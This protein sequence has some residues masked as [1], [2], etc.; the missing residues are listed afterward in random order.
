MPGCRRSFALPTVNPPSAV[1]DVQ[2]YAQTSYTLAPTFTAS[3]QISATSAG[4]PSVTLN[5]IWRGI[6]LQYVP[7]FNYFSLTVRHSQTNSPVTVCY[8]TPPAGAPY[9]LTPW[10]SVWTSVLAPVAGLGWADGLGLLGPPDPALKTGASVPNW[11][12]TLQPLPSFGG[13]TFL[14]QAYA[15]DS[16]L[17]PAASAYMISNTQTVTLN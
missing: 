2:G 10:G 5:A 3:P 14:F 7:F 17:L 12:V 6:S 13:T 15:V 1:T 16:S 9:V 8:E 11:S 4:V